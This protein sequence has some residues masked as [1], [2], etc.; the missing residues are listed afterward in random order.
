MMRRRIIISLIL[1]G[2]LL[3]GI[4]V[5]IQRGGGANGGTFKIKSGEKVTR[6]V[7][8]KAD[9]KVT[10]EM[11]KGEWL[12]NGKENARRAAISFLLSTLEGM[13]PESSVSQ[14]TLESLKSKSTGKPVSVKIYSGVRK[15]RSFMVYHYNDVNYS[16]IIMKHHGSKPYLVYLPG[17][18]FD[19]G[20][21]FTA[22]A[23]YWRPFTIFETMPSAI[24]E[25]NMTYTADRSASFSIICES[26]KTLLEGNGSFDTVAV[27][28]YLSYFVNV[29]FE[30]LVTG[31]EPGEEKSLTASEPYFSIS[32]TTVT[33]RTN[34]LKGWK[35]MSQ[36]NGTRIP[37]TDRLWGR[38]DDG[39][40]FVMR[41]LDIDPLLKK[42]S[43]F[44]SAE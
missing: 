7:I 41:Y 37:D 6:V 23:D 26:G 13:E 27:K 30:S 22:E 10:L 43:Y 36:A 31:L 21:V 28:R 38:L 2:I 42:R 15:I 9:S 39:R 29:P 24:K 5:V 35:R 40:L 17:Y 33:G 4:I 1:L 25:M 32:L 44:L 19:P 11:K 20:I 34:V 8:Q 16:S 12:V 18:D 14:Q 3:S